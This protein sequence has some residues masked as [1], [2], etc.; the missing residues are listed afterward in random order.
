MRRNFVTRKLGSQEENSS[1]S[2]WSEQVPEDS[3]QSI[4]QRLSISDYVRC[5][6]VCHSWR[7]SVDMAIA[8]KHSPPAPQH[9][10]L[11]VCSHRSCLRDHCFI[12]PS[13]DPKTT[14]KKAIIPDYIVAA[15]NNMMFVALD[16][17]GEEVEWLR[18]FLKD[19]RIW[20]KPIMAVCIH[21]DYMA[22]QARAKNNVYNGKSRHIR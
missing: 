4:L 17:A 7:A 13:V 5:T 8:T 21:C 10:L 11:I 18:I 3:M 12:S 2:R 6:A 14:H 15:Y 16:K 1:M 19:I 22:A 20:P 9:P